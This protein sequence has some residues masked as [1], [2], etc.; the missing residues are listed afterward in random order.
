ML[1][2][3]FTN[4][5]IVSVGISAITTIIVFFLTLLTKR[6]SETKVLSSKLETEHKFEQR[7]KIKNVLAKNKV[8]L[9]SACEDLNHR[10]WNFANNHQ[11]QWLHIDGDFQTDHYYF[12]SFV[13]RF[14]AVFAWVEKIKKEIIFLDTTIATKKDLEFIK[15]INLF[16]RLFCDLTFVEGLNA[17]GNIAYDHFYRN[18]FDQFAQVLITSNGVKSFS[19]YKNDIEKNSNKLKG[20]YFFFDG[21]SPNENRK[22]WDRMHFFHLTII[23]FLNNYGY[24]FQVTDKIK[25]KQVLEK[26]KCCKYLDNYFN[27]LSEYHIENNKVIKQIKDI[28]K[29]VQLANKELETQ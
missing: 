2:S 17:N 1:L 4:E 6:W 8:H 16:S 5:T 11:E 18:R 28:A 23:A 13:Y 29:E 14:L 7:K 9:I 3:I 25:I 26:P 21:L 10:Y 24:D 20:L 19:E 15:F 12:H 27:F 22:R